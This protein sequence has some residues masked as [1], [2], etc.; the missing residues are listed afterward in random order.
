M[1]GA[2]PSKTAESPKE[3]FTVI[4][5]KNN[6]KLTSFIFSSYN[7]VLE[8]KKSYKLRYFKNTQP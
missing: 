5:S 7:P 8:K 2:V 1:K 3:I 6:I 4:K